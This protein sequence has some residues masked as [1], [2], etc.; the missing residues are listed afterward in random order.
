MD[1]YIKQ[2]QQGRSFTVIKQSKPVFN[3][4][5]I[6][7]GGVWEEVIDFTRVKK[8]GVPIDEVLGALQKLHG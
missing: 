8:G 3:I 1:K 6:D 5:P 7:E 2:T 4:T